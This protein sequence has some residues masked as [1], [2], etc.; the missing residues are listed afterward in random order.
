MPMKVFHNNTFPCTTFLLIF[1]L[2]SCGGDHGDDNHTELTHQNDSHAPKSQENLLSMLEETHSPHGE[3]KL[4]RALTKDENKTHDSAVRSGSSSANELEAV[5]QVENPPVAGEPAHGAKSSDQDQLTTT[6]AKHTEPAKVAPASSEQDLEDL[7]PKLNVSKLAYEEQIDT[8]KKM[9]EQRDATIKTIKI[10]NQQLR[11][12]LDRQMGTRSEVKANLPI[13]G[14]MQVLR[15]DLTNLK[16]TF[17]LKVKEL[18]ELRE[19]NKDLLKRLDNLAPS[20]SIG[21]N[22]R[23]PLE[24]N[25]TKKSRIANVDDTL[26]KTLLDLPAVRRNS[27]NKASTDSPRTGSLD[28]DAVVTAVNGK[29]KEAFY[30]EFFV[31]NSDLREIL[32]NSGIRLSNFK[33]IISHA[34]LWAK[35]RKYPF[36][37]PDLQ[38]KIR[39]AL[40]DSI[41]DEKTPGRRIRTDIDGNSGEISGLSAGNYYIIGTASLGQVGVT[42]SVPIKVRA[43]RNKVSLTI[44]NASWSL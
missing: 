5:F 14:E 3:F 23:P 20:P 28:F 30:T 42:W 16:N 13:N 39:E 12:E 11:K 29:I 37:Y 34:E 25:T 44:A 26:D 6:T 18:D 4:P 19:Y 8:L 27:K 15:D 35:S 9:V 38:K 43:G 40:L 1:F 10:I 32:E 33:D 31:T 22:L 36:R 41:D 17:T 21:T 2:A 24:V 7:L